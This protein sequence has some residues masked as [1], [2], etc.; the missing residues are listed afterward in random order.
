MTKI[1]HGDVSLDT[2]LVYKSS[3]YEAGTGDTSATYKFGDYIPI[4]FLLEEMI[5]RK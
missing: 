3:D 1:N 5:K 2:K 4:S